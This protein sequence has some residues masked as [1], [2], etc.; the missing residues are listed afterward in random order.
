MTTTSAA[1]DEKDDR[2]ALV[3]SIRES[4]TSTPELSARVISRAA[5]V[6]GSRVRTVLARVETAEYAAA[7]RRNGRRPDA[8]DSTVDATRIAASVARTTI[9][10]LLAADGRTAAQDRAEIDGYAYGPWNAARGTVDSDGIPRPIAREGEHHPIAWQRRGGTVC[11]ASNTDPVAA[12]ASP[13]VSPY[14]D[15]IAAVATV[16]RASL[17]SP[18]AYSRDLADAVNA[19]CDAGADASE[20]AFHA[21]RIA[22]KA[23]LVWPILKGRL[24][25][26]RFAAFARGAKG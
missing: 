20:A 24:N 22:D 26:S 11:H 8:P 9:R 15:G 13:T 2:A 19:A 23:R 17:A 5:S 12:C 21:G 14:A 10:D 16:A 3:R 18:A 7:W 25:R 4:L 6:A 1:R